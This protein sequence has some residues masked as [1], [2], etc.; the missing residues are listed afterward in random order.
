MLQAFSLGRL[1]RARSLVPLAQ[2]YLDMGP[3]NVD[4]SEHALKIVLE[5]SELFTP[6]APEYASAMF[7]MGDV[8]VRQGRDERANRRVG[9]GDR[10]VPGA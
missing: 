9:G 2:C 5:Q 10:A 4:L 3:E 7:L 1:T 6:D 8:L